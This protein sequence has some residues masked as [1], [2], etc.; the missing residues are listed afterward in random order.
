MRIKG[1]VALL[2]FAVVGT[3]A[4]GAA[5]NLSD[6]ASQMLP[7]TWAELSTNGFSGS[8]LQNGCIGN[9]LGY[10]DSAMWDPV[11][12]QFHFMGSPHCGGAAGNPY[13]LIRYD[14]ASNTWTSCPATDSSCPA[15]FITD[16]AH[17]YEHNALD[18][19]ARTWYHRW[20]GSSRVS[21]FNFGTNGPWNDIPPM[22]QGYS[23]VAGGLAY[24]PE[25]YGGGGGLVFA[26]GGYGELHLWN[27]NQNQWTKV[28]TGLAMG[29][30]HNFAEYNP[31][32]KV[33]ICGGGN[34]SSDLY[35]VDASGSVMKMKNAPIGLGIQQ[36]IIT[37]DPVSGDYLVLATGG[38]FYVYTIQSVI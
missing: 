25:L 30:Y 28:A 18:P 33:V 34:G 9:I 36:T 22:N 10:A 8:L 38:L 26:Q 13:K 1:F 12:R 2:A 3:A 20:S 5:T 14:D 11:G 21:R 23:Q 24:F 7:G 31:V 6:K 15:N 19:T 4:P 35:K 27:K 17:A 37:V 29:P 32:H 16:M